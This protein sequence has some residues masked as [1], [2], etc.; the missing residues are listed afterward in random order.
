MLTA[1]RE[2]QL[3]EDARKRL[4]EADQRLRQLAGRPL[5]PKDHESFLLAQ[6]LLDQARKALAGQEY[7]RAVTLATKARTLAEDLTGA[8]R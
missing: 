7:E 1:E 5:P 2:N 8:L 3:R 4:E 6:S